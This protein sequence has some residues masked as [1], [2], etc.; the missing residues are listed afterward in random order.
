M[1]FFGLRDSGEGLEGHFYDLKK[2]AKDHPTAW[3]RAN[4]ACSSSV[5]PTGAGRS[6]HQEQALQRH[7][8][9]KFFF[10]RRS[11]TP[12]LE[13]PTRR[14]QWPRH[15]DRSIQGSFSAT[16]DG[17]YRL[18]GFGDNVLIVRVVAP[19]SSTPPTMATPAAT[20]S[21][22]RGEIPGET[23]RDSR[24]FRNWFTLRKSEVKSIDVL[25]GDEGGIYCAGFSSRSKASPT[26]RWQRPA[27]A[28]APLPGTPSANEKSALSKYP[29]GRVPQRPVISDP[30][31]TPAACSA[32][33]VARFP[34]PMSPPPPA[35]SREES[36]IFDWRSAP[37][38]R[39]GK[40]HGANAK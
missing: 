5:S 28:P 29:P 11:R 12:R 34:S 14:R 35:R 9:S 21:W 8:Y 30:S 37:A 22:R 38:T 7:P 32:N 3:I 36:W 17:T 23:G 31:R 39:H 26:S 40:P 1:P 4:T 20:E 27:S 16:E 33:A 6:P 24:L 19:S 2:D 18:V 10:F 13:R 15:L 25:V